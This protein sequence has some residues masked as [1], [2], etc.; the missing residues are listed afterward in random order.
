[1]NFDKALEKSAVP[2][3]GHETGQFQTYPNY[4]EM[5]KYTG[6]L[7]PR[8]FEIFRERLEEKGMLDQ[9]DEF[10]KASGAWS[11]ELYRADIEMNL[12]SGR[13]A[14]FQLLDLQDYPGQGSAYV[15]ILDAF[16]DS[17]GLVKPKKW[18]EFCCEVVPLLTTGKYCWTDE[19]TFSGQI[20]IANYG[21]CSLGGKK[22]CWTLK[23]N[24][25][26]L[27]RGES[28]IP[29]GV[30][31]LNAGQV[32]LPLPK[33]EKACKVEFTVSIT[34]TTYRNSY[35]L[36]IYPTRKQVNE[37]EV[38]VARSLTNDVIEV[39]KQ[40]RKV[41]LMP[42]KEDCKQ[43]TVGG[44]FQTDYWNF[45]MFK[46]I[47]D[48]IGKPA[49]PGTL[50]ILTDPAHPVFTDFPTEHHTNWQWYPVIKN[51]YPLILDRLPKVFRPI[52]QVIDNVERNHKLGLLMEMKVNGG[53]LM[54]CMADL[55]KASIFPEGRQFY[56]SLLEYMNSAKFDPAI[57][58]SVGALKELFETNI[59]KEGIKILDNIS[60]D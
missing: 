20:A 25:K 58:I 35:S 53:R 45:R 17:K 52:V 5:D 34:G 19:E 22:V 47:C 18:R 3:I 7:M 28:A 31:L 60:Y 8:N 46:S 59:Q 4:K 12:R 24:R 6:V 39:L 36:W 38:L 37:G 2:V 51:S 9:A 57:S 54:V 49:S 50:G 1:M 48:R 56:A 27:G 43:V 23:N 42:D 29:E 26:L 40:G 15:G 14:G 11:V 21:G 33:V 44:L 30:G 41:L 13:M 32:T 10:L 55:E 16:M